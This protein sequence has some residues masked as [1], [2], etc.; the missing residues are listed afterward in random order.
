MFYKEN[1]FTCRFLPELRRN[2]HL[3]LYGQFR[4]E[5][6]QQ[7]AHLRPSTMSKMF[8][9]NQID[10]RNQ[11]IASVPG[12]NMLVH[13]DLRTREVAKNPVVEAQHR[14]LLLLLLEQEFVRLIPDDGGY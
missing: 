4:N 2:C 9:S 8:K 1:Q 14:L 11:L 3:Q 5:F 12:S 6:R 7:L 13:R 10:E